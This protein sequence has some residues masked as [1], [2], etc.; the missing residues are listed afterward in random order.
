MAMVV[1]GSAEEQALRG[2]GW[3]D[4]YVPTQVLVARLADVLGDRAVPAGVRVQEELTDAWL[5]TYA[6]SRPLPDDRTVVERI[7][8]SHPPR[9][10]AAMV[11]EATAMAIGRGH[12][13]GP[14]LGVAAVWVDPD[15]RRV[16]RAT[17][18]MTALGHWAARQGCR[19]A[20]IQVDR[21]NQAAATAYER[22]GFRVHH[23]YLYLRPPAERWERPSRQIR[24]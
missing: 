4:T 17:A 5:A 12:T 16:G 10:F 7:L 6:R 14:W 21:E 8:D 11:D 15:Q 9:A 13:S 19:Y 3:V 18:I 22:L 2:L 23:G 20:Y 24:T 1:S